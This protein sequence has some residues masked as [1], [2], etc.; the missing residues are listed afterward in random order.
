MR[1]NVRAPFFETVY[2]ISTH[3]TFQVSQGSAA[4]DLRWGENFTKFWLRNSSLY[5]VLKKL[6]KSVYIYLSYRKNKSVSFFMGHSVQY[7]YSVS[8]KIP[9]DFLSHFFPKRLGIFSPNFTCLLH[10]PILAGL[11]INCLFNPQHWRAT[12]IIWSKC[13][14]SVETHA[15]WSHLIGLWHNFVTVGGNCIKFCSL[16]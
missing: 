2:C 13:P 5:I 6:R 4:T 11:Q 9:P 8:Q 15:W 10:I 1:H 16:A 12:T 7:I 3:L 14:P